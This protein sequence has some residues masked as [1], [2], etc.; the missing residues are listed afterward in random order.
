MD[1]VIRK[2]AA[3]ALLALVSI[4][5]VK[6]SCGQNCQFVLRESMAAEAPG[7]GQAVEI[8]GDLLLVGAPALA[9]NEDSNEDTS[10]AFLFRVSDGQLVHEL[11]DPSNSES[12]PFNSFGSAI[13]IS[14]DATQIMVGDPSDSTLADGAG[15]VYLF[16]VASGQLQQTLNIPVEDIGP[17]FGGA[18]GTSVS[19]AGDSIVV[20]AASVESIGRVYQFDRTSFELINTFDD[21]NPAIEPDLSG[22]RDQFGASVT[23]HSN[24]LVVGSP[25]DRTQSIFGGAAH[26]FDLSTG[27]LLKTI[28]SPILD[29]GQF[30]GSVDISDKFIA[31]GAR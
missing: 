13:A 15:Q 16:D 5:F 7:F 29:G 19:F 23:V 14:P 22:L 30:G 24:L 28:R 2:I 18:F 25:L 1:W 27:T 3:F 12:N 10:R 26:I 6:I 31:I 9:S 11:Q 4:G 17:Q 20:G 21:P 8:Q